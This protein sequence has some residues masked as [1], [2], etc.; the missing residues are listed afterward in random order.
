MDPEWIDARGIDSRGRDCLAN[1]GIYVFNRDTLVDVL[2]KTDYQDFGREI[3]PASVRSRRVQVHLFDGYW[4]DIGTIKAF[5]ECNLALTQP[6]PP[7]ELYIPGSPDLFA[8]AIP[9]AD[10]SQWCSGR[11]RVSVADGGRIGRGVVIEN[12]IIGLRCVIGDNVTIR[13]SILMGADEYEGPDSSRFTGPAGTRD[14]SRLVHRRGH[15]RQELPHRHQRRDCQPAGHRR[16]GPRR[17]MPGPRR[18]ARRRQGSRAAP[19]AGSCRISA[20]RSGADPRARTIDANGPEW[21][22]TIRR[23][24]LLPRVQPAMQCVP[25]RSLGT[26][27][28]QIERYKRG[29]HAYL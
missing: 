5:Y 28:L 23:K 10:L 24:C 4:E 11:R 2:T 18:R 8:A 22:F 26:R 29:N 16:D 15:R 1:M 17:R 21:L 9:A 14:R 7:F 13:N 3:F 12:S 25:T 20:G 6:K 27:G 19:T